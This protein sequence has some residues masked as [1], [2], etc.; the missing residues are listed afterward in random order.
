MRSRCYEPRIN[1]TIPL[2]S[3]GF[4][5]FSLRGACVLALGCDVRA[6]ARASLASKNACVLLARA[7]QRIVIPAGS[8]MLVLGAGRMW[9]AS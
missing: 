3:R 7:K 2:C 9:E 6:R 4:I 8:W 1:R 5:S